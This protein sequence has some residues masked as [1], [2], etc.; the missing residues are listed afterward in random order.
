MKF[1][2]CFKLSIVIPVF[3]AEKRINKCLTSIFSLKKKIDLNR[4][5]EVIIIN[6]NSTDKSNII[7]KNWQKKIKNLKIIK[8][9]KNRGVSFSRNKGLNCSSGKYVFFSRC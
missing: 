1:K 2:D 5:I 8:N 6:D 9:K 3:N 4:Y 7:I